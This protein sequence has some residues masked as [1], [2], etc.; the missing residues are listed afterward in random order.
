[1]TDTATG[2]LAGFLP[3][4]TKQIA[5]SVVEVT[6][7]VE[8]ALHQKLESTGNKKRQARQLNAV[9]KGSGAYMDKVHRAFA[10]NFHK[11]E[12]YVCR[13]IVS[14]PDALVETVAQLR[15]ERG[16]TQE[17]SERA[18]REREGDGDGEEDAASLV[19][20]EEREERQVDAQ[21]DALRLRLRELTVTNQRLELEQRSLAERTHHFQGLLSKVAFLD[22]VRE[23]AL[24][25]LKRTAEHVTALRSALLQMDSVQATLEEDVR[26]YKRSKV[27]TRG[28]FHNLRKRFAA[29]TAEMTYRTTEDLEE[30]H[31]KLLT[32]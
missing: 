17:G 25:P 12:L 20:K 13:N 21:L 30:L 29:R 18:H 28:T 26:Q 27:A 14:V 5:D 7:E 10:K 2:I 8:N 19:S 22:D 31:A 23:R 15:A 4:L 6:G 9:A 11:F 32:M 16:S 24:L 1:M 3:A